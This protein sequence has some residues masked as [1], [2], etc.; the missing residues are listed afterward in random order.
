VDY[1]RFGI[2]LLSVLSDGLGINGSTW[3]AGLVPGLAPLEM[4][5]GALVVVPSV[6]TSEGGPW[7]GGMNSGGATLLSC[8]GGSVFVLVRQ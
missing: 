8:D 5:E 1:F 3:V 6:S 4:V 2:V 7:L